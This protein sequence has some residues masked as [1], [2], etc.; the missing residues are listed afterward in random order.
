MT[1]L[2]DLHEQFDQSPWLD[3]LRRGWITGGQLQQMI[4]GGVRGITSNPTIFQKAIEGGDAYDQQFTSLVRDGMS[5]EDA[6][7]QLVTKDIE[8][9]LSLLRPVYDD[10]D[11][12]DGFVS[13][14]VA[15]SLARD[16]P[17]TIEAARAF[18]QQIDE[19]NLYVKIPGTAE[20]VPAIEAMLREGRSINIT[21][22]FSLSRY[23]EVIEAYL[24][25]LEARVAAGEDVSRVRS[26]A[27]FFVSRVDTETDRRLDEI[28]TPGA[29][30]LKG[31][32]AV[33]NAQAAY[34]LFAEQF[35]GPRWEALAAKGAKPQRPLWASTSTK[36][37]SYPDT[38]YVDRL[39]GPETVNT[40]PEATIDAFEDH[41]ALARTVDADPADARAALDKLA[42]VGVELEDVART[43]EDE[44]VASFS[45]SFDELLT[46]LTTKANSLQAGG[47]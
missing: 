6:Y 42:S 1:R 27:S 17:A 13:I 26:V 33:A 20:G 5:I 37:P 4:D 19:P 11:G 39:I 34:A 22:L 32:A 8:D 45:K 28:G 15:P 38:M 23:A 31:T 25:A 24:S 46:S 30:A 41:G 44:G 14:E 43:L 3:N 40:L 36:N 2:Q 9:A 16:T 29:L 21:L 35:S 18:H 10:S 12:V 7:W 47:A